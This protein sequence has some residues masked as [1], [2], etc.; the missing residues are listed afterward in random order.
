VFTIRFVKEGEG[1][2]LLYGLVYRKM[3]ILMVP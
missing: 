1:L 3:E 2:N